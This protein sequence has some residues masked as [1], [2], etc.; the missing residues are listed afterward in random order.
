[1][2]QTKLMCQIFT[3]TTLKLFNYPWKFDECDKLQV[4]LGIPNLPI[5]INKHANDSLIGS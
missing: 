3:E 4:V 1:M 5:R 2:R